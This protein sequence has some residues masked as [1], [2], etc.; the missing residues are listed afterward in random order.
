[1]LRSL[2]SPADIPTDRCL[3]PEDVAAVIADCATGRRDADN[4][5]TIHLP[6]P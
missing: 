3:T 1:M 5:R 6:S 2:F 4:G